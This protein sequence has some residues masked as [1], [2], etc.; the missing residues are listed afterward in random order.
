M[1]EDPMI[2]IRTE[3]GTEMEPLE[4]ESRDAFQARD[5]G[6]SGPSDPTESER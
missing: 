1:F 5:R 4:V 3:L 2:E 6:A